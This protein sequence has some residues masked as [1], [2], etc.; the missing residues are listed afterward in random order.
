MSAPPPPH[1]HA[2]LC[3][4]IDSM[5]VAR[6]SLPGRGRLWIY[7]ASRDPS[8]LVAPLSGPPPPSPLSRFLTSPVPGRAPGNLKGA[9][10]AQ[11]E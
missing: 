9:E 7:P 8:Q 5:A 3:T 2:L 1:P 6:L 4:V 10:G 11:R